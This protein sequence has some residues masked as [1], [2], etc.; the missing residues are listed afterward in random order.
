M[1]QTSEQLG[2][3]TEGKTG[4]WRLQECNSS[5]MNEIQECVRHIH[6]QEMASA[7]L[8]WVCEKLGVSKPNI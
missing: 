1:F 8:Y 3:S 5:V 4:S 6:D 2:G 7:A